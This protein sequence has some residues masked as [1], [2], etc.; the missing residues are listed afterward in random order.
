MLR[1]GLAR[2]R[3]AKQ[4]AAAE[5]KWQQPPD[6]IHPVDAPE[7]QSKEQVKADLDAWLGDV[8]E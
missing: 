7:E 5:A 6:E 4:D 1:G 8:E 2:R 3:R